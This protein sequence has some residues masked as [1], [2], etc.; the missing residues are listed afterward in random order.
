MTPF[1]EWKMTSLS[2]KSKFEHRV[3]MPIPR[4]TIQPSSNSIASRSHI[5][6]RVSPFAWSLIRPS[7]CDSD[8]TTKDTKVS[9]VHGGSEAVQHP[10]NPISHLCD[11]EIQQVT[12]RTRRAGD[13]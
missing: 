4:L 6:C 9:R 7:S 12:H 1:S 5:C 2:P 13:S 3:G 8:F 10:Y 11:M